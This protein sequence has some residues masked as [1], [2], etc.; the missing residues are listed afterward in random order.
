VEDLYPRWRLARTTLLGYKQHWGRRTN[1]ADMRID[2]TP[3]TKVLLIFAR[4]ASFF[5]LK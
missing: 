3:E 2:A 4:K 1:S 5:I